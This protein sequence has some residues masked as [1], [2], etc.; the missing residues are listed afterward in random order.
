MQRY[1]DGNNR[2]FARANN[3]ASVGTVALGTALLVGVQKG[4]KLTGDIRGSDK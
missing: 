1:L 3:A 2:H 4:G